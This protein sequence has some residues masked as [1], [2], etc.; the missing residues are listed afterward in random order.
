MGTKGG[1][2]MKRDG[3]LQSCGEKVEAFSKIFN[4]KKNPIV[5]T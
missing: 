4:Y 1:R 3:V 5:K 2:E